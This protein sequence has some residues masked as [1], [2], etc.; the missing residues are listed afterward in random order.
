MKAN[1]GHEIVAESSGAE[2][3][4][5]Q[6]ACKAGR[7]AGIVGIARIRSADMCTE[8]TAS[9]RRI[10]IEC[11]LILTNLIR[12]GPNPGNFFFL[13]WHQRIAC[14]RPA[15]DRRSKL[16]AFRTIPPS[17]PPAV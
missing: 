11:E 1:G 15:D 2:A 13:D 6:K 3:R 9:A 16:V 4:H 10:L 8:R 5:C 7:V 17:F 14:S 12:L